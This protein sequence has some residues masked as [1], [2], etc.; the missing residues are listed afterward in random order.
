M[1]D[2][3]SPRSLISSGSGSR[4]IATTSTGGNALR[5]H[6]SSISSLSSAGV[7]AS[8]TISAVQASIR[9]RT[10][11]T[12]SSAVGSQRPLAS[13]SIRTASTSSSNVDSSLRD[14]R[15]I[16][17]THTGLASF[18]SGANPARIRTTSMISPTVASASTASSN[19]NNATSRRAIPKSSTS[20]TIDVTSSSSNNTARAPKASYKST[21]AAAHS[22]K[23]GLDEFGALQPASVAQRHRR[24]NS[25]QGGQGDKQLRD[26]GFTTPKAVTISSSSHAKAS[27]T[28]LGVRSDNT[29]DRA[30]A[31][32]IIQGR[33]QHHHQHHH[34][35]ENSPG[36]DELLA[37]T[38]VQ[39]ADLKDMMSPLAAPRVVSSSSSALSASSRSALAAKAV[40]LYRSPA[41]IPSTGN[42]STASLVNGS[43]RTGRTL[44][45]SEE[46]AVS[47]I[48]STA[49]APASKLSTTSYTAS[50]SPTK[51][52]LPQLKRSS[53]AL[54]NSPRIVASNPEG[55]SSSLSNG[56]KLNSP[57]KQHSLQF[58][59][60]I[61]KI[62]EGEVS[63]GDHISSSASLRVPSNRPLLT[64]QGLPL[65]PSAIVSSDHQDKATHRSR[66]RHDKDSSDSI[67]PL[68]DE[69]ENSMHGSVNTP[70]RSLVGVM[71][72]EMMEHDLSRVAMTPYRRSDEMDDTDSARSDRRSE[73]LGPPALK[74]GSNA[75]Q[76]EWTKIRLE[77]EDEHARE[78]AD[79]Q[80]ARQNESAAQEARNSSKEE[81]IAE[82]QAQIGRLSRLMNGS[83]DT[84]LR[85]A[86]LE[87]RVSQEASYESKARRLGDELE[88]EKDM[89]K[90]ME[91]S[92]AIERCEGIWEEYA[93][94]LEREREEIGLMLQSV[95]SWNA[96]LGYIGISARGLL[97]V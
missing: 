35:Q 66:Y 26:A 75:L 80:A 74:I 16:S 86:K 68:I 17:A 46:V 58:P 79:L 44:A 5:H 30:A 97:Q 38:T 15:R 93:G 82:L 56:S 94:Q 60:K 24:L 2:K 20:N 65:L 25:I 12:V 37:N 90:Q 78:I 92:R 57:K 53:S 32:S 6:R 29:Q 59:S 34:Q 95:E 9:T 11:S 7:A 51:S 48:Q 77:M 4:Q 72:T 54:S 52:S 10:Y 21:S 47:A 61:S 87:A 19:G 67:I 73:F 91:W 76:E 88:R 13:E 50:A 69:A 81:Q 96:Y 89:K 28:L 45:Q 3:L 8:T 71:I 42:T 1:V 43:A 31:S 64:A 84:A 70:Q 23:P 27:T 63:K 49:Q 40:T 22:G 62:E 85:A 36:L 41:P 83:A 39:M 14:S 55:S 33:S 18:T